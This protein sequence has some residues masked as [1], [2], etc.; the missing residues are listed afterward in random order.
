[1]PNLKT[2]KEKVAEAADLIVKAGTLADQH[3]NFSSTLE[4]E[5]KPARLALNPEPPRLLAK[6]KYEAIDGAITAAGEKAKTHDYTGAGKALDTARTLTTEAAALKDADTKYTARQLEVKTQVDALL[7]SPGKTS[8][9]CGTDITEAETA[10]T[11]AGTK[12]TELLYS[13]ATTQ[14]ETASL[15]SDT[16][17]IKNTTGGTSAPPSGTEAKLKALAGKPGGTKALDEIVSQLTTANHPDFVLAAF[18]ARFDLTEAVLEGTETTAKNVIEMKK[19]YE[20]MTLVPDSH[21]RENPSFK[22]ITRK[23][24]KPGEG[25]FYQGS[26]KNIV[27]QEGHPDSSHPRTVGDPTELPG[28]D[29]NCKPNTATPTPKFFAWNT[30]HEVGHALDDKKRY[31]SSNGSSGSH[32]GWTEYGGDIGA[33]ANAVAGAFGIDADVIAKYMD[34]GAEPFFKPSNWAAMTTW[35]AA[36]KNDAT[37]FPWDNGSA[38]GKNVADGGLAIGGKIYHEAYPKVWVSYNAAARKQGL[39]GYQFRA[40]GEWFSELYAAYKS[41]KLK[42]SHPAK[43]WLDKLFGVKPVK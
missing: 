3:A 1:M 38:C 40:P 37:P 34:S 2:A 42:P 33:V 8:V 25:S 9:K 29:E 6:K 19:L 30:L 21:T 28:V 27:M 20:V 43:G 18:K 36:A 39:T 7:L 22:K 31:M 24:A 35:A 10:L 5:I 12:A 17:D 32:G 14:L 41:E 11:E 4:T 15:K 13:E 26:E 23:P 16:A